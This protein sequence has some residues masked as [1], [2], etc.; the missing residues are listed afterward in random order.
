MPS[1]GCIFTLPLE[2]DSKSVLN[3]EEETLLT[4]A[5]DGNGKFVNFSTHQ[6]QVDRTAVVKRKSVCSR[7]WFIV[8]MLKWHVLAFCVITSS[9]YAIFHFFLTKKDKKEV[10]AALSFLDDWKQLVFFFGIYLSYAVKKVGDIS[11]V[12]HTFF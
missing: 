7:L 6:G 3:A 8:N 11:A 10:L 4:V 1:Q 12:S 9:L 2:I 5:S